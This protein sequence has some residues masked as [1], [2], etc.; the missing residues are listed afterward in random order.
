MR[1][2]PYWTWGRIMEEL[3]NDGLKTNRTAL[4]RFEKEGYIPT[5]HRTIG[6][7]RVA[8]NQEEALN[9]MKLIW[10]EKFGKEEAEKYYA[11]LITRF[12]SGADK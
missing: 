2:F 12:N 11:K 6:K 1:L 10:A 3:E 7:W 9:V 4:R 8:R 5:F